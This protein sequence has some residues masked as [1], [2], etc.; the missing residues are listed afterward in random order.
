M[1]NTVSEL[2]ES[3]L[4]RLTSGSFWLLT[5]STA[6]T[7]P[8]PKPP[9]TPSTC[10]PMSVITERYRP[11]SVPSS[12]SWRTILRPH[13][14]PV[15]LRYATYARVAAAADA[16]R[17]GTGPDSDEIEPTWI[18]LFVT[19][20]AVDGAAQGTL[21]PLALVAA[22]VPVAP[23]ALRW[24]EP[25][26]E[27]AAPEVSA[28]AGVVS[29]VEPDASPAAAACGPVARP[30]AATSACCAC[31]QRAPQAV[32]RSSPAAARTSVERALPRRCSHRLPPSRSVEPDSTA[33]RMAFPRGRIHPRFGVSAGT[34][35][36]AWSSPDQQLRRTGT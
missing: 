7:S 6:P 21:P 12:A 32:E 9:A 14:P 30:R 17:P 31:V 13:R 27:A 22:A 2:T 33:A 16:P 26:D 4:V 1:S 18:S 19:P 23:A 10:G 20:G 28:A 3:L 36:R 35:R 34:T 24:L 25:P 11:L 5:T 15:A 8:K 29:D